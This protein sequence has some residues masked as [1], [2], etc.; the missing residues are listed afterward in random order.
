[1][2]GLVQRSADQGL[3][4]SVDKLCLSRVQLPEHRLDL[5]QLLFSVSGPRTSALCAFRSCAAPGP[6]VIGDPISHD[7]PPL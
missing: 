7:Y 1:M 6:L 2:S 4:K 5:L 3:Y